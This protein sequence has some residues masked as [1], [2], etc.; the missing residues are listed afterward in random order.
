MRGHKWQMLKLDLSWWWYYLL[1]TAASV[2]AYLDMI[3]ELLG[4]TVPVDPM[5]MF[6][7]TLAVYC[8][9]FTAL[10]LWKKCEVDASYAMAFESIAC[11]EEAAVESE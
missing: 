10:S 4:I 1:L 11:P 5:V 8:V 3:L 9:L 7:A 6:F 2:V